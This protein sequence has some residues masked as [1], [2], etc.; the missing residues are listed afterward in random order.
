[1]WETTLKFERRDTVQFFVLAQDKC[2][3]FIQT[4]V[5]YEEHSTSRGTLYKDNQDIT[6]N[7][8]PITDHI[9]VDN[10]H[11]NNPEPVHLDRDPVCVNSI[12]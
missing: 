7:F 2:D 5:V 1:L 11:T 8:I 6:S 10:L 3:T 12:S 4:R 9:N